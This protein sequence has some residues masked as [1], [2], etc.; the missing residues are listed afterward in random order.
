MIKL[1]P[2]IICADLLNLEPEIRILDRA[3]VDYLHVD[4]MD[5]HYVK[6][7]GLS[8]DLV[9]QIRELT[10][11]PLD[12]H[13]AMNMPESHIILCAEAGANIITFHPETTVDPDGVIREI[14][15]HGKQA[16]TAI[17]PNVPLSVL[18]GLLND[19]DMINIL[20]VHPGFAGQKLIPEALHKIAEMRERLRGGGRQIS[21]AVDGNVSFENI[22]RMLSDGAEVLILGTSSI[23]RRGSSLEQSIF[24]VR[25]CIR[26][27]LITEGFSG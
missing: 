13:L 24:E 27:T 6:N 1:A 18:E 14:K 2:S 26:E 23:F 12:V 7:F 22:P 10:R 11:I 20:T 9:R 25:K 4:M 15:R 8:Y 16:C 17:A 3:G 19:I 5:G 21:I